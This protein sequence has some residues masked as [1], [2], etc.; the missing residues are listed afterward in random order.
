MDADAAEKESG[1]TSTVFRGVAIMIAFAL[2][3]GVAVVIGD[4]SA[5]NLMRTKPAK[6]SEMKGNPNIGH[7]R[8]PLPDGKTCR[9]TIFNRLTGQPIDSVDVPCTVPPEIVRKTPGNFVWGGTK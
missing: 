1:A 2:L 3:V 5:F 4:T 7:S 9:E 6:P 8:I